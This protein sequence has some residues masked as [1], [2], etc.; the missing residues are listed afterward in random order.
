[1]NALARTD[2]AAWSLSER[3]VSD[4][5]GRGAYVF[6]ERLSGPA[7]GELLGEIRKGRRFDQSLFLT[8]AEFIAGHAAR[9][10]RGL[11]AGMDGKLDFVERAPQVVEALW[12]LLGPDYQILD[13]EVVCLLPE[14]SIPAWVQRRVFASGEADLTDYVRP[15]LRDVAYRLPAALGRAPELGEHP[16]EMVTLDV[17][18]HAVGE[19]EA[20]LHLLEGSH[21]MGAL[22]A[23]ASLKRTGPVAWRCRHGQGEMLLTERA[24]VGESGS[25]VL[26]HGWTLCGD[27]QGAQHERISLSYRFGR[28]AVRAA[29]ID[30]VNA[31]LTGD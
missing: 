25:A 3:V 26:R 19:T 20:P 24:L 1:M 17:Y 13:R 29:G 30:T 31:S 28:G 9:R 4:F 21:R 22:A 5:T 6:D 18:L 2:Y 10:E 14:A 8:E 12:S 15:G 16:C 23:P 27:A 7:C 11:L